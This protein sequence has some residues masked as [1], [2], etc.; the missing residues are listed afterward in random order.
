MKVSPATTHPTSMVRPRIAMLDT[1]A[2]APL[3]FERVYADWFF[4]VWR[5]LRALGGPDADLE[6]LAQET[7]LVVKRK[8][9]DFDGRHLAA[10][11]YR[12]AAHTLSDYR[13]RSWFRHLVTRRGDADLD[14]LPAR[15]LAPAEL[16]EQR[17][18]RR[19]VWRLLAKLKEPRR[20]AFVLFEIEGYSGDEIAALLGIPVATV[21]TRLHYARRDFMKLVRAHEK[22]EGR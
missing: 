14:A 4:E 9:P 19:L 18:E 21:W 8:L 5:W 16:V 10:W 12:I 7:F 11:L 6:D 22:R 2:T 13:R 15:G 17:E 3:A 20:I 1:C